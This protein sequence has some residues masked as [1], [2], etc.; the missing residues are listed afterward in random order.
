[1]EGLLIFVLGII[2]LD[3]AAI[4]WGVDTTDG[5]GS[6]EWQKRRAWDGL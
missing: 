3:L 4:R 5:P 6:N 1:M 2:L